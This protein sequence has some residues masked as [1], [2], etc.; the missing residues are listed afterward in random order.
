MVYVLR[1][2][3]KSKYI[4]LYGFS[5]YMLSMSEVSSY[6]L[7]LFEAF[8]LKNAFPCKSLINKPP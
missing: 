3:M 1:Q 6:C 2:T 8:R 5:V 4:A 7:N